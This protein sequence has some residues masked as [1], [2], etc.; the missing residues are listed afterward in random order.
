MQTVT[1]GLALR[2][3]PWDDLKTNLDSHT[4][5]LDDIAPS[6]YVEECLPIVESGIRLPGAWGCHYSLNEQTSGIC[7]MNVLCGLKGCGFDVNDKGDN[8]DNK[9]TATLVSVLKQN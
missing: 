9:M 6:A 3:L 4:V 7:M 8:V 1:R 5:L 2:N